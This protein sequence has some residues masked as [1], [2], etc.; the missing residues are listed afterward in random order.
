MPNLQTLFLQALKKRRPNYTAFSSGL[1]IE[2]SDI[3]KQ[4]MEVQTIINPM[5]KMRK[6]RFPEVKSLAQNHSA[7]KKDSRVS[8]LNGFTS[9]QVILLS[10]VSYS[11]SIL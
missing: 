1:G 5:L 8:L 2:H 9:Q 11:S 6:L 3:Y 4:F 7:L 10:R